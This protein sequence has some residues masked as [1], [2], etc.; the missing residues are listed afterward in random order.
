M[1]EGCDVVGQRR[2]KPQNPDP[3][4]RILQACTDHVND[5]MG[6]KR[7]HHPQSLPLWARPKGKKDNPVC[8]LITMSSLPYTQQRWPRSCCVCP[9]LCSRSDVVQTSLSSLVLSA[10]P[11]NPR[12]INTL[13]TLLLLSFFLPISS[14]RR[15][16]RES[17]TPYITLCHSTLR[18]PGG[19]A[20]VDILRL[21]RKAL[22]SLSPKVEIA[23]WHKKLWA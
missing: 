14:R 11:P 21:R 4:Q 1:C 17:P 20:D 2:D 7:R 12:K 8:I 18:C 22:L 10:N 3:W 9:K 16:G 15:P 19:V 13:L 6:V 5:S 23:C